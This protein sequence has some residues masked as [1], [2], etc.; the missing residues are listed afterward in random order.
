M[1]L[2]TS[3][4]LSFECSRCGELTEVDGFDLPGYDYSA[5]VHSEGRGTEDVDVECPTCH[6]T[7]TVEI[8]NMLGQ[9][10]AEVVEDASITVDLDVPSMPDYDDY[11]YDEYLKSYVPKE[12]FE[13]YEHSLELLDEMLKNAGVLLRYPMFHRMMLLQHV[14]MMEAYLCD[15]LITLV[16]I[17]EVRKNLILGYPSL[18]QQIYPMSAFAGNSNLMNE[19]T[20]SFLKG[21]L[22]HELDEV[23][24]LYVAA[25]GGTPFVDEASMTFL[26]AAMINRHHCVHRDGKDNDGVVLEE[27]DAAY[28]VDVRKNIGELVNNIES[29]FSTEIAQVVPKLPF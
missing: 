23:E 2:Q 10:D 28:I 26:K 6:K 4:S 5:E 15:R 3:P 12:P 24:K 1:G 17:D 14:A 11:D 9:Y 16:A 7:Y 20:V 13:R 27:V 29:K 8:S 22:Y 18:S 25:L 19:K 21:Q